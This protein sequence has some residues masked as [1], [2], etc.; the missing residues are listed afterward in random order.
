MTLTF[1]IKSALRKRRWARYWKKRD[2]LNHIEFYRKLAGEMREM[3]Q[4]TLIIPDYYQDQYR[5]L[6][7]HTPH[8]LIDEL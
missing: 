6:I 5:E 7:E 3:K 2:E 8:K 4:H 1:T